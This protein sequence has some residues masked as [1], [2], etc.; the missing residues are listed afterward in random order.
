MDPQQVGDAIRSA[1]RRC[2]M[3]QREYAQHLGLSPSRLARLEVDAG[4]S[5]WRLSP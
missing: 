4:G 5:R 1:R 2:R 3:S